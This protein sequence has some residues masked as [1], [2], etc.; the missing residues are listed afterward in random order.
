M[1][2]SF[3]HNIFTANFFITRE[4]WNIWHSLFRPMNHSLW[5]HLLS[6]VSSSPWSGRGGHPLP[7]IRYKE[8]VNINSTSF[9]T[10]LTKFCSERLSSP[11]LRICFYFCNLGSAGKSA[12]TGISLSSYS[13][14]GRQ[15]GGRLTLS[16][17]QISTSCCCCYCQVFSWVSCQTYVCFVNLFFF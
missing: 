17:T 13:L 11:F 6:M 2:T 16:F 7:C 8:K 10:G 1:G 14:H 15:K 12:G 9:L 3:T 4:V 5:P